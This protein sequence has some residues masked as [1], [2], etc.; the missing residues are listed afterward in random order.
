MKIEKI[1]VYQADLPYAGGIYFL[2]GGR[3]YSSFDATIVRVE[4]DT[5]LE[6]WGRSTPF[7]PNYIPAHALGVRAGI[8]EIAPHLIGHDP[9]Q[10][11]RLYDTMNT[12][13]LGHAHAIAPI[14]IACWDLLGK[15]TGMPCWMLLGGSTGVRMPTISSIYASEPDDMRAR[16]A[17]HR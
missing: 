15:A 9:R 5:G 3:Q 8:S 17:A 2:S 13:L 10:L 11:E 14:D 1:E 12:A 4:T 6:G 7:G 16:V